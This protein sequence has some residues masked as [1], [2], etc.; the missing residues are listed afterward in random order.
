VIYF[1][2]FVSSFVGIDQNG[3]PVVAVTVLRQDLNRR[4]IVDKSCFG[5][6]AHVQRWIIGP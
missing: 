6:V 4:D 2:N 1:V 5:I 3:T